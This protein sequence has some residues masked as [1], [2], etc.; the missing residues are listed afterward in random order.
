[1][2]LP[3]APTVGPYPT[4]SR[5]PV[6][7]SIGRT[8]SLP[9][10]PRSF[11]PAPSRL[12][13]IS[14]RARPPLHS[15]LLAA[16]ALATFLGASACRA[17]V[18]ALGASDD[19]RARN[20]G[21]LFTALGARFTQVHREPRFATARQRIG[22]GALS[23]STIWNDTAV[24]V[25]RT[26]SAATFT[27]VGSLLPAGYTMREQAL[28]PPIAALAD[29]RHHTTLRKLPA[30]DWEW[31][32]A[33]DFAVGT[34]S[35]A[36]FA[37][38]FAALLAS[39]A[40]RSEQEMRAELHTL[41]PHSAAALGR[42]VD[43]DTLRATPLGDGSHAVTFAVRVHPDRIRATMPALAAFFDRHVGSSRYGLVLTDATGARWFWGDGRK[44]VIQ[45]RWRID[46]GQL[47][48]FE[49]PARPLPDKLTLTS[50]I[51]MKAGMFS[52]GISDL[53]SDFSV[54][55]TA[56]ERGWEMHF[57]KP[58]RWHLPT[59]LA[60]IV[61]GAR[62]RPFEGEGSL[63]RIVIRD[64]PGAE[65]TIS[66]NARVFVR[67]SAVVRWLGYLGAGVFGDYAG[68]SEEQ[69]ARFFMEAFA[70]L[71]Q[72]AVARYATVR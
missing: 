44:N 9:V 31:A 52:V 45:F 68:L 59:F 12:P 14:L 15:P 10:S 7:P 43:I 5:S 48:P 26:D 21:Q 58:P 69:E 50:E 54:V 18:D 28:L 1:M 41:A 67:E 32:S 38:M 24:W 19:E 39:P 29:G 55:R 13:G 71:R 66:R 3:A 47:A 46:K 33:V 4:C 64:N 16:W 53:A 2:G 63:L 27:A 70:A 22:K 57:R 51:F 60:R 35:S 20:A 56:T 36:E 40:G 34:V 65:T 72:D 8:L 17:P 23:P 37:E 25:A 11:N 61:T 62:S 42:L 30:G 6:A 49:G